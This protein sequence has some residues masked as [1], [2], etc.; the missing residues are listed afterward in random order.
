MVFLV[1]FKNM[2]IIITLIY[3]FYKYF[4]IFEHQNGI[5]IFNEKKFN[6]KILIISLFFYIVDF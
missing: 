6:T 3:I 1:I 5:I 2:N 4:Y